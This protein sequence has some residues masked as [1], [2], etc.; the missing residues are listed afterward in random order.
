MDSAKSLHEMCSRNYPTAW[1]SEPSSANTLTSGISRESSQD[2]WDIWPSGP[3]DNKLILLEADTLAV[4]CYIMAVRSRS[5]TE[6]LQWILVLLQPT[7]WCWDKPSTGR[8]LGTQLSSRIFPEKS[9]PPCI[10]LLIPKYLPSA[11]FPPSQA[12]PLVL[13]VCRGKATWKCVTSLAI[14]KV[15]FK[16]SHSI[17]LSP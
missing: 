4:T 6:W 12:Q 5:E 13:K 15:K 17:I 1:R 7:S 16:A 3:C 9:Q 8:A 14:I 10:Y 2:H 11:T